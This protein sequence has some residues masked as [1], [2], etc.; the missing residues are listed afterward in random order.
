MAPTTRDRVAANPGRQNDKMR[1]RAVAMGISRV[2][3]V[4]PISF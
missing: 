4:S 1:R 3:A 2:I